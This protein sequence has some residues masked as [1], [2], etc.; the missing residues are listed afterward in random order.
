MTR[1]ASR[2]R[3]LG[4][5]PKASEENPAMQTNDRILVSVDDVARAHATVGDIMQ[6]LAQAISTPFDT[7]A[8]G[9]R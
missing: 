6:Q 9:A 2:V 7:Q 8:G 3:S 4:V 1:R 5:A